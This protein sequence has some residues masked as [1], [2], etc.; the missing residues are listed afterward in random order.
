M[1][2]VTGT[3]TPLIL[4]AAVCVRNRV[5]NNLFAHTVV[6]FYNRVHEMIKINSIIVIYVCGSPAF[7]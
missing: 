2:N 1:C 3:P 7:A 5:D 4:G 6:V